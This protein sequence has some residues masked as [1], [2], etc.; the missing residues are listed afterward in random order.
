MRW[1]KLLTIYIIEHN[2]MVR[3]AAKEFGGS[4]STV[5]AGVT[6]WNGCYG[7]NIKGTSGNFIQ[8]VCINRVYR[9]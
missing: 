2:A 3:Q 1:C 7:D 6:K 9:L 5:D 8:R 4:K